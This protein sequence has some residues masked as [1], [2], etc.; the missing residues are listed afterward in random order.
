MLHEEP[1]G[2][3]AVK[4][5][6]RREET[7]RFVVPDNQVAGSRASAFF[8]TTI[9]T[10]PRRYALNLTVSFLSSR[11]FNGGFIIQERLRANFNLGSEE[12]EKVRKQLKKR[13]QKSAEHAWEHGAERQDRRGCARRN[14]ESGDPHARPQPCGSG[15]FHQIT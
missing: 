12:T 3:E 9:D 1:D 11:L 15:D 2:R 13:E 5:Q 6:L 14:G 8:G 7:T 10:S 4:A